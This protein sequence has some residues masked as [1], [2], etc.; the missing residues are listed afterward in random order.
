M[1]QQ[2]SIAEKRKDPPPPSDPPRAEAE[3]ETEAVTDVKGE[4]EVEVEGEG[5]VAAI[6][7]KTPPA[8][9][10]KN[11]QDA[12]ILEGSSSLRRA[13]AESM[14]ELE[15]ATPVTLVRARA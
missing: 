8:K 11:T 5:E 12:S 13:M 9:K 14:K 6:V 15:K 2:R 7:K 3:T 1:L 4:A 10:K